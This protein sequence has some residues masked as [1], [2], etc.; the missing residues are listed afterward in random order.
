MNE[1]YENIKSILLAELNPRLD[2]IQ[3][4]LNLADLNRFPFSTFVTDNLNNTLANT[5]QTLLSS[6]SITN[7][8]NLTVNGNRDG[9]YKLIILAKHTSAFALQLRLNGDAGNNYQ[10]IKHDYARI[11]GTGVTQET[12]INNATEIDFS[13]I[14]G[15]QWFSEIY[16]DAKS[17]YLRTVNARTSVFNDNNNEGGSNVSAFWNNTADN[18]TSINIITGAITTGSYFL[19]KINA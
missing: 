16:I 11:A 3:A 9:L 15:K 18:L 12:D 7:S 4:Q 10:V 17:G 2:A 14:T 6:N 1:D 13:A 19:Y 8:S 5:G